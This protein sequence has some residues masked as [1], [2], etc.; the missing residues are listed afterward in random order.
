MKRSILFLG[1][2]SLLIAMVWIFSS[3]GGDPGARLALI[4]LGAIWTIVWYMAGHQ[5]GFE[6]G[7]TEGRLEKDFMERLQKLSR[8]YESRR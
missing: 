2:V 8:R 5:V 6:D 3:I 7:F 1:A 4:A